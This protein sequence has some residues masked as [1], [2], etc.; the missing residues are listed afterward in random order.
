MFNL[1]AHLL[2]VLTLFLG[3]ISTTEALPSGKFEQWYPA[4][5]H[6]FEQSY[7]VVCRETLNNYLQYAPHPATT[8]V[9]LY[10]A[11]H[12]DC[13]LENTTETIKANMASAGVVLGL[14][15]FSLSYLGPT[16]SESGIVMLQRPILAVLLVFG[17]PAIYP[18]RVFKHHDP[19]EAL[20]V[21]GERPATATP[22]I[23]TESLVRIFEYSFASAAA[24]NVVFACLELGF[25]TVVSWRKA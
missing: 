25:K 19:F 2:V 4:Y 3:Q 15:P 12:A 23:F 22:A 20:K 1:L 9:N 17:G 24:I 5:R 8:D 6:H 14:M 18:T 7:A 21:S 16:L 10:A 11:H 13:V